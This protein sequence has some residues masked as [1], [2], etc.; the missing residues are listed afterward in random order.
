MIGEYMKVLDLDMDYFMNDIATNV[1]DS[2][3]KRL[4]EEHYRESVWKEVRVRDFIENNLGLSK[5]RKTRGRIVVGHNE[6][7]FFWKELINKGKLSTPFE[8]V[9]VD[10]HADLGLGYSSWKYILNEVLQYNVSERPMH[11]RY[12]DCWGNMKEEGIGDYLLWA[13]AYQWI[14]KLTYCA[15]PNGD[16]N[17]YLWDILKDFHENLIWDEPVENVIQ[18]VY[19][20]EMDFPEYNDSEVVK[21]KYVDDGKKEPEVP[22]MIIP[23]IRDVKYNGDF[24]FV[25]IAQSPNYTPKSADFIMDIFREYVEEI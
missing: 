1:A 7:L 11:N 5:K 13:I 21:K 20:P 16:K 22:M 19:N 12:I 17:D 4:S 6:S 14:S 9:H 23:T 15:N 18:L 24:D 25:V 8:V 10:S 3:T 2:S